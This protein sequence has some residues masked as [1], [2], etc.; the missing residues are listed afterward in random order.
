MQNKRR[1]F[2]VELKDESRTVA[3]QKMQERYRTA[4]E[5]R[6]LEKREFTGEM[7]KATSLQEALVHSLKK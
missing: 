6:L 7:L 3:Q 1:T 5:K 4:D 2:P